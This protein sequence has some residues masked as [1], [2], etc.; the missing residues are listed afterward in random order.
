MKGATEYNSGDGS[1]ED[2]A[3]ETPDDK[4]LEVTLLA[5]RRSGW[6]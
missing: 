3:I 5:P 6:A 1:A 4:T 2:V